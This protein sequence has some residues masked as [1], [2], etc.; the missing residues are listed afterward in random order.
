M[1]RRAAKGETLDLL[2][3]GCGLMQELADLPP[4]IRITAIDIDHRATD[5]LAA[6]GDSRV[7]EAKAVSPS[8]N[9]REIGT[10][11]VIYAKEV[12]EHILDPDDYFKQLLAV[13]RPGG[14]IWLST[15]NYGEPWLPLVESTFL[16]VVARASGFTRKGIHPTPFSRERL[17]RGLQNAGFKNVQVSPVSFR[18]ALVAEAEKK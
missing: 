16:E 17:T 15:P 13:L 6:R 8:Q 18:L 10:F 11:D 14:G 7:I 4:N 12:I 5:A 9:L 1:H 3:I 2:V